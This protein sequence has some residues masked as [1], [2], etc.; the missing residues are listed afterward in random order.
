MRQSITARPE[1]PFRASRRMPKARHEGK[2]VIRIK[3]TQRK[4]KIDTK[5]IESDI[6][7]MLDIAGYSDFDI[8]VWFT[9]NKTI[10]AYNKKY[11]QKDK[12]TDIL[13]FPYHTS[14][15]PGDAIQVKD[16]E[17]KNLGDIIISLEFAKLDLKTLKERQITNDANH[18]FTPS[19]CPV[20]N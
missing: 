10:R 17:D 19:W 14:L 8:G 13:S 16:P 3:N 9:T 12:P 1:E 2:R 11:R 5:K 18:Y 7:R 15:K 20:I 6:Q 4:I